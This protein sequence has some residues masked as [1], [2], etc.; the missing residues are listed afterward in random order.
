MSQLPQIKDLYSNKN[1][2]VKESQLQIL[3]NQPPAQRWIKKHPTYGNDY[4]PIEVQEWLLTSI[5]GRWWVEISNVTQMLNSAV[6][7]VRVFVKDPISGE[8]LWQ[9]G[10]GAHNFQLDKDAKADDFSKLKTNAVMLAVPIAESRAFSDACDKF[11][12]IFGKDLNR[13]NGMNYDKIADKFKE[14]TELH[15]AHPD[16]NNAKMA[17]DFGNTTIDAIEKNYILSPE[18][19]TKL[20]SK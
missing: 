2:A 9:D 19:K 16:W 10:V 6:V 3:L 8:V 12:K 1:L 17:L 18:N 14:K 5:F 11:G 20:C 15:P 4:I 7:T 13:K